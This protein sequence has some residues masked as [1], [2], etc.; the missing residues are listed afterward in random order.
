[1]NIPQSI[2][3][4]GIADMLASIFRGQ[5]FE[6]EGP[7]TEIEEGKKERGVISSIFARRLFVAH[8]V[9]VDHI[10]C[11]T[12]EHLRL[13]LPGG[14]VSNHD[15]KVF[16]SRL[17]RLRDRQET[18]RG[19]LWQAVAEEHPQVTMNSVTIRK[20]WLLVGE[21][22]EWDDS[23][24]ISNKASIAYHL[25][26]R[27]KMIVCD[28]GDVEIRE[29]GLDPIGQGEKVLGTLGDGRIRAFRSLVTDI[30]RE[31]SLYPSDKE[32]SGCPASTIIDELVNLF[33]LAG[34]F[35]QLIKIV[36]SLF[37]CGVRDAIPESSVFPN[38]GIRQGWQVVRVPDEE[39]TF[40]KFIM[41]STPSF[42]WQN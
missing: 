12:Q 17:S 27:L 7:T 33:V 2:K 29:E 3:E 15:C 19:L 1:M 34:R 24:P 18:L 23:I 11:I 5:I 25:I 32:I 4:M 13:H 20:G 28:G 26:D 40:F 37:W 41:P 10:T 14:D 38:I 16:W 6:G 36:A 39:A 22:E 9:M 30:H 35:Q 42:P 31:I 8:S 21:D